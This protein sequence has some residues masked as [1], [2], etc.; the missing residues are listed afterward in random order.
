M[1]PTST[2]LGGSLIFKKLSEYDS[3]N[4]FKGF[5]EIKWEI[6]NTEIKRKKIYPRK[7][8][9]EITYIRQSKDISFMCTFLG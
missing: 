3:L 5:F 9:C 4:I 2:I 7:Q 1:S 6:Q 8:V